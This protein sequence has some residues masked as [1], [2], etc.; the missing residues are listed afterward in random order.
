MVN[1]MSALK[2]AATRL[3]VVAGANIF[4]LHWDCRWFGK[5]QML[6][7]FVDFPLSRQFADCQNSK[8]FRYLLRNF[9]SGHFTVSSFRDPDIL[10][11]SK[12]KTPRRHVT[13]EVGHISDDSDLLILDNSLGVLRLDA[14]RTRKQ[15]KSGTQCSVCARSANR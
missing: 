10:R 12:R 6:V 3:A 8:D 5:H 7:P 1:C 4:R 9:I 13:T 14:F 15:P 11:C 2:V